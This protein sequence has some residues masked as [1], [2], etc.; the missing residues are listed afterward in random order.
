MPS[1]QPS[2]ANVWIPA[3]EMCLSLFNLKQSA[4]EP[5]TATETLLKVLFFC[6]SVPFML[7]TR[8]V[9]LLDGRGLQSLHGV[10]GVILLDGG[11][12]P[13]DPSS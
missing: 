8:G 9:I 13:S 11:V 3:P 4:S 10:S 1:M 12:I 5:S 6:V 7:L 2:W